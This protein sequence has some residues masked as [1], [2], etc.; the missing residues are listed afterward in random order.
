MRAKREHEL[1]EL[2]NELTY[3]AGVRMDRHLRKNV[4]AYFAW[5]RTTGPTAT[6]REIEGVRNGTEQLVHP[7]FLK[8]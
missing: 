7:L 2:K 5:I 3:L 8:Q 1:E 4:D 6:L